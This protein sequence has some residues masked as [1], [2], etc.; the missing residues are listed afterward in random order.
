MIRNA[1]SF[2]DVARL[3]C[4][5]IGWDY[6]TVTVEQWRLLRSEIS[7]ALK[8]AWERFWWEDVM[9]LAQ[10]QLRP[11]WSASEEYAIGDEVYHEDS[12]AYYTAI[13]ASENQAPASLGDD[14]EWAT[15]L[16]YW[17]RADEPDDVDQGEWEPDTDY[18]VGD[19][20][21]WAGKTRVCWNA[22][23]SSTSILPTN[24]NYWTELEPFDWTVPWAQSGRPVI[25]RVKAVTSV[26]PRSDPTTPELESTIESNGIRFT[27]LDTSRPWVRYR[28]RCPGLY[29]EPWDS[30][31][32]Y[33][34]ETSERAV[35]GLDVTAEGEPAATNWRSGVYDIAAGAEGGSVTGLG[36]SFTPSTAILTVEKPDGGLNLSASLVSGT[37]SADGFDFTLSGMTDSEGY[38]LSYLLLA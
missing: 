14:D 37:L 36:L 25:G 17:A 38:K 9:H 20:V 35:W 19:R 2:D 32:S 28:V 10:V 12:D 22:H 23:T 29:G 11:S 33:S 18:E 3:A 7:A 15:N 27:D 16:R 30:T 13:W 21:S 24:A 8:W 31:A 34:A 6:D 4:S 1:A 26:D 5:R